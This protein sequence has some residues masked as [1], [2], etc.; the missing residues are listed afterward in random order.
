MAEK[1]QQQQVTAN[2]DV[3]SAMVDSKELLHKKSMR[4]LGY[5]A[6][7]TVFLTATVTPQ[8]IP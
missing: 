7:F 3:E 8:N 1:D 4:R 6:A 2:S 5:A